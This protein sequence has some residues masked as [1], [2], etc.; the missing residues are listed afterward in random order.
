MTEAPVLDR[1]ATLGDATRVRLLLLLESG[2]FTVSELGSIL[3]TTQPTT[4][5]HLKV[6]HE[7]GWVVSR[8]DGTRRPY[9]LAT[10]L[11]VEAESLWAVVRSGFATAPQVAEDRE[12]AD[13]VLA[14]R[15]DR[16][17][18]FFEES[19]G[20]W[21]EVR[22]GLFGSRAELLPLFGLMDPEWDVLDL[23]SGT[24]LLATSIAPFVRRV[25]GIDRSPEMLDAA[26]ARARGQSN[27]EFVEG[28]LAQLPLNDGAFDLALLT[29]VLHYLPEP[30]AALREAARVLRPGGRLV[31]VDM[32][33][34][35]RD[36]YQRT[37][38]HQWPGF[39]EARMTT[40]LETT[41]FEPGHR[42]PIAPDP[43][44]AGP[45]LFLQTATVRR[46]RVRRGN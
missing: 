45:A 33:E 34:H 44:A 27:V 3:Q 36:E 12:R 23:G 9:S 32:R 5:R 25:T 7:D 18:T 17:R 46:R 24:G 11:D 1:L 41:G 16:A 6:L 35:D 21:D 40:W 14:A 37:M 19:A 8:Q 15:V 2:E 26:R 31:I 43:D 30:A 28:D 38:G 42:I 4:S 22:A 29:L 20:E 13:S 39:S 10:D